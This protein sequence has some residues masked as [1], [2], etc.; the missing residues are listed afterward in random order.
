QV[1]DDYFTLFERQRLQ[2]FSSSDRVEFGTVARSEPLRRSRRG[3]R[4]VPE[5]A[6]RRA[7]ST[8][9]GIADNAVQPGNRIVGSGLLSSELEEGFLNDVLGR[10]APLPRVQ[11][12]RRRVLIHQP[13]EQFWS[14]AWHSQ[15]HDAD[16]R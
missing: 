6:A 11:H 8:Q 3:D 12:K 10:T 9:G 5:P 1:G 15:Q 13:P 14:N 2:G 7:G 16:R 4:F